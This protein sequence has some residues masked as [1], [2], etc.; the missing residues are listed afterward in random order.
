MVRTAAD[1]FGTIDILLNSAGMFDG[2]VLTHEMDVK[3]FD[4][5]QAVNLRGI[6]LASKH[7]LP[8]MMKQNKGNIVNIA[9]IAGLRASNGGI[10]YTSSKFGVIGLTQKMAIEYGKYH[11]RINALCPGFTITPFDDDSNKMTEFARKHEKIPAGR[12]APLRIWRMRSAFLPATIPI[13]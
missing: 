13:I 3:T 9:S 11:V 1:A 6:F 12:A 8:Y 7:A 5:V 4:L 10:A 2:N